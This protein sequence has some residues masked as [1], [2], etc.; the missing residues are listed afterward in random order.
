M[1]RIN[2][3][4]TGCGPIIKQTSTCLL[5]LMIFV[6]C[7]QIQAQA[8]ARTGYFMENATHRH[9]MNPA[10]TPT[11][12]YIS[13][14]VAGEL[15]LGIESN[16][17]FTNFIYP[18]NDGNEL[19]TFLHPDI[20]TSDFLS[21]LS[22]VNYLRTDV[23]TSLL[24]LGF[25]TGSSFWTFDV[26]SRTNVSM[27]LPYELFAF[28]KQGMS[29][30]QGNLY[31]IRNLSISANEFAEV[32]LGYSRVLSDNLRVG[33]KLK[34]LAGGGYA[35]ANITSMDIDMKPD[36]WRVT[37][38]G[39]MDIYGKGINLGKDEEGTIDSLYLKSPGLGGT[40]FAVDL[41]V[42]YSPIPNL[43]LSLAVIDLGS[44]RWKKDNIRKATSSGS[45][46]FSG[47]EGFGLDSIGKNKASDQMETIKD[48]L[49]KM[50]KF[51]ETTVT[52]NE[53]QKLFPTINAG[54]EYTLLN[55]KLSLGFLY[56]NR[57]MTDDRYSEMTG[58]LNLRPSS[59]FNFSGSYSFI[60]GKKETVGFA[61]GFVPA[62]VNIFLACDY[63]F[64]HVNPQFIPL[65]TLT[66]NFQ[67]GVSVPLGKG[68]LP[69][70]F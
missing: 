54:A 5:Y 9:L 3:I 25:Y 12:G 10:L 21:K 49:L 22:P 24:S 11:R 66:T 35:K 40:G 69:K 42:A 23:R 50:A 47:V 39:V 46:T 70:M 51:K 65:N 57:Y 38:N 2:P 18:S 28:L 37:T 27:N 4:Y 31:Q 53:L 19:V 20:S 62:I 55:N 33:G 30:D 61:L 14:P 44:I 59:W 7:S 26:A 6:T 68:K 52:G 45:V 63:T 17:Q 43:N 36:E 60:H 67:L 13:L 15:S 29:S 56:S 1:K 41:G 48:D 34:F 64:F 8:I 32:A 16:M 58:S